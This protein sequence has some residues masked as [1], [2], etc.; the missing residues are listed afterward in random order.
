MLDSTCTYPAILPDSTRNNAATPFRLAAAPNCPLEH[1]AELQLLISG[2]WNDTITLRVVVG[3]IRAQDPIPDGPRQPPRYWAYDECDTLYPNH[4]QFSWVEIAGAPST[5]VIL[6]DDQTLTFPLPAGFV[7]RYYGQTYT[8]FSI[9]SNGFVAPGSTSIATYTNA[10]LPAA[11]MPPM[12]CLN[13]DDLYPP[14]GRGIWYRHQPENH[15][16]IIEYDSIPTYASRTIWETFQLIIYDTTVHTTTGDNVLIAQYLTTNGYGSATV[17][18][19][20]PTATIAIQCLFDG[21]YHRGAARLA[22]GRAIKYVTDD[23][24]TW[25]AEVPAQ[26]EPARIQAWPNPGRIGQTIRLGT[27]APTGFTICDALGR[28]IR[29]LEPGAAIWD[30]RDDHGQ[31]VSPGIYFCRANWAGKQTEAKLILTH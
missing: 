14:E 15:R 4:P 31:L 2:T 17:G 24:L 25:I 28:P 11:S 27:A 9:C 10:A 22:P 1:S 26:P 19:Q 30:G 16:L 13:W 18:I 21:T 12:V 5:Q 3:E 7:W 29:Q 23:P 6:G 8:Q 20:D